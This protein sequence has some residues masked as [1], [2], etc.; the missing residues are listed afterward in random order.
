M[1]FAVKAPELLDMLPF[2]RPESYRWD[3]IGRELGIERGYRRS[4][5]QEGVQSGD[6]SKLEG[7]LAKW[8]DSSDASW[9]TLIKALIEL[10]LVNVAKEV[11]EYLLKNNEAILKYNW[12]VC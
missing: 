6:V 7:I 4:L 8:L 5:A 11:K 2:L 1:S 10:E 3:D 12:K 9:D